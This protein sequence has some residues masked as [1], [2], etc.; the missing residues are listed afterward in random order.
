MATCWEP[1][2]PVQ[3][4]RSGNPRRKLA[5]TLE[6]VHMGSGWVGVHTGRTNPVIAEGISAGK[7]PGLTGYRDLKREVSFARPG[8]PKGRLDIALTDGPT[9]DVLVEVKNVT[10]LDGD[11]LRFPDAVTER[12][13]KHLGLL[14]AAVEQ[15]RRGVI[16]FALNRSEGERFAPAWSIDPAYGARLVEAAGAGV[17]VLAVRIRHTD[18]GME[19]GDCLPVDLSR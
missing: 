19:T 6:R 12:G 16:L 3:L 18:M 5:W 1:G 14:Q 8:H 11:C 13:R 17:E 2:A 9:A 4:S 15:G 7:I 10:L